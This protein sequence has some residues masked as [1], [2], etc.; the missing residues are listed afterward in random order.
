MF[1]R[2]GLVTREQGA[3]K[4]EEENI[5]SQAENEIRG[6]VCSSSIP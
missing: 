5:R 2:M 1:D 3:K 4:A 6:E